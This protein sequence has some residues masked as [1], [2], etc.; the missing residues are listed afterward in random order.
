M[1]AFL[2]ADHGVMCGCVEDKTAEVK[3]CF[4]QLM[5][6]INT[7]EPKDI[8]NFLCGYILLTV[9]QLQCLYLVCAFHNNVFNLHHIQACEQ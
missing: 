1:A 2:L 7:E 8:N 3:P 4:E 5:N 9:M 6:A